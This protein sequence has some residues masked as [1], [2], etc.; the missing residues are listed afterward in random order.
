MFSLEQL[1][2]IITREFGPPFL[3][4][5]FVFTG[6]KIDE[7][8]DKPLHLR[9][10]SKDI[11]MDEEGIVLRTSQGEPVAEADTFGDFLEEDSVLEIEAENLYQE[12]LEEHSEFWD[13]AYTMF[14]DSNRSQSQEATDF[15]LAKFEKAY[16]EFYPNEETWEMVKQ[17]LNSKVHAGLT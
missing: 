3:E 9:I 15:I 6:I 8:G 14:P 2:E 10:G 12:A 13:E 4:E 16:K 1:A 17:Y 11:E 7:K 5:G